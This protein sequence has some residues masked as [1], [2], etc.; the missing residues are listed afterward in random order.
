MNFW[1]FTFHLIR[2]NQTNVFHLKSL[3]RRTS[4][5][6]DSVIAVLLMLASSTWARKIQAQPKLTITGTEPSLRCS[7]DHLIP[8]FLSR[9]FPLLIKVLWRTSRK[10]WHYSGSSFFFFGC[11][12]LHFICLYFFSLYFLPSSGLSIQFL[13]DA[14]I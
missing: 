11:G 12:Q 2:I 4:L 3:Y 14:G 6:A 10:I 8:D 13:G 9:Y 7:V 1:L 5:F